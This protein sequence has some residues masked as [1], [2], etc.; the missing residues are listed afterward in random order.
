MTRRSKSVY[1]GFVP[2][3]S[4]PNTQKNFTLCLDT[5][6][7]GSVFRKLALDTWQSEIIILLYY[8]V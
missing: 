3:V 6:Q 4:V 7:L 5:R 8:L 1:L 2:Q